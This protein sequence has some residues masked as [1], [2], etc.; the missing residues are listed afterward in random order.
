MINRAAIL[1]SN[2]HNFQGTLNQRLLRQL[3]FLVLDLDLGK[4]RLLHDLV[5]MSANPEADIE[6]LLQLKF[7][8]ATGMMK[9]PAFQGHG[10]EK[11]VALLFNANAGG[12]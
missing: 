12:P 5:G 4:L 7:D 11:T 8:G 2:V 6:R 1:G 9:R 3:E 10:H